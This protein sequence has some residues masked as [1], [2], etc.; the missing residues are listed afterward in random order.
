M[1]LSSRQADSVTT[2]SARSD[3][4]EP[5]LICADRDHRARVGDARA[6]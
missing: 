1:N 5:S 2:T 3:Q 4:N 6:W